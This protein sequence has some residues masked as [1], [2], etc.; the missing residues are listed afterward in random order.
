MERIKYTVASVQQQKLLEL[1]LDIKDAFILSYLKDTIGVNSKFISKIVG[2][3]IYYW[4][5]YSSLITYLPILK[6]ESEKVLARRFSEYEKLGLLKRHIH[7][8][9]NKKDKTFVGNYTFFRLTEQFSELFEENKVETDIN[10][11]E[12]VAKEMGLT[13]ENNCENSKVP[14]EEPRELFSSFG[15]SVKPLE[16]TWISKNTRENFLVL[17][18]ESAKTPKNT[19]VCE[20]NFEKAEGTQKFRYNTTINNTIINNN[21]TTTKTNLD[22]L[23]K[24]DSS[25]S[26]SSEN[27]L[28][29]VLKKIEDSK[30]SLATSNNIINLIVA[31]KVT[32]DKVVQVLKIAKNKNW[33]DGAIYQ[34]L[35]DNWNTDSL[36]CEKNNLSTEEIQA[37]DNWLK[38]FA[39]I[40]SSK[41]LRKEFQN[42]IQEIPM[43]IL[44]K[45]KSKLSKMTIYEMKNSL[46]KLRKGA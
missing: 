32:L 8:V 22:K 3:E 39:G 19:G 37:R 42:I 23:D 12:K 13:V 26:S 30:I 44:E 31:N 9:T 17:S 41:E 24:I 14:S 25:S 15:K 18:G 36:E 28:S 27:N 11:L 33:G 46:L 40:W 1:N 4:L 29:D 38:R 34:A 16:N 21:N 43:T 5:K 7:R 45:N 6:I 20:G 35:R 2:D 10:E